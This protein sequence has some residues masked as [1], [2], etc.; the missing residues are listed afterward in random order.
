MKIHLWGHF[1]APLALTG[2]VQFGLTEYEK[3]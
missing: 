3:S 2:K 1:A